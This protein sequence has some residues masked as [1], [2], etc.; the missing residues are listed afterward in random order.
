MNDA[1][2]LAANKEGVVQIRVIGRATFKISRELREYIIQT[3]NDGVCSVI[4]DLSECDGMDS[5]FMGVMAMIG[6]EAKGKA[7]VLVVNAGEKLRNLLDSI[8]VSRLVEYMEKDMAEGNWHN[9]CEAAAERDDMK[10]V[11][12]TVRDAHKTLMELSPENIPK[13]Q[14]VVEMLSEELENEGCNSNNSTVGR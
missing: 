13:F 10:Q 2:I 7:S 1:K 9:L 12:P 3:L 5:T 4:I 14:N 11:A 8:G 6:L